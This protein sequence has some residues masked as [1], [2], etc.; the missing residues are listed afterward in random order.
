MNLLHICTETFAQH[1]IDVVID[2]KWA[3]QWFEMLNFLSNLEVY[4]PFMQHMICVIF[5]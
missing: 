3:C 5:E 2:G 1:K 4:D